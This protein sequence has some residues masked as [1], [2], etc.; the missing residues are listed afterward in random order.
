M[1]SEVNMREAV[2]NETAG[3]VLNGIPIINIRYADDTYRI[4]SRKYKYLRNLIKDNNDYSTALKS[5]MEIARKA[6]I[7]M[8]Q[9]S[10][11]RL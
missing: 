3:E 1:Y 2:H 10:S 8:K 11:K 7:K 9:F 5:R 4:I 6:F